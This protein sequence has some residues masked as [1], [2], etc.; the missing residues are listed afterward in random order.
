MAGVAIGAGGGQGVLIHIDMLAVQ[1]HGYARI[2]G[3]GDD[4]KVFAELGLAWQRR[5]SLG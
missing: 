1:G 3:E 4:M 2:A 5:Q